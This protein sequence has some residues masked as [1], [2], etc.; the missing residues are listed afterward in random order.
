M[1]LNYRD[2]LAEV[3]RAATTPSLAALVGTVCI[4]SSVL[5]LITVFSLFYLSPNFMAK[6]G[7]FF[8]ENSEDD[9]AYLTTK[10]LQIKSSAPDVLNVVLM[11]ASDFK[12]ALDKKY[13][14]QV[15]LEETGYPVVVHKLTVVGLNFWEEICILD[16]I[17]EKLR[18]V[19]VLPISASYLAL[20]REY[21]QDDI[22]KHLR[23]ALY[24]PTFTKEMVR[25]GKKSPQWKGNYF[26]DHKRFFVVRLPFFLLNMV[27]NSPKQWKE[28][29]TW[30]EGGRWRRPTPDQWKGFVKRRI[31]QLEHYNNRHEENFQLY[32]RLVNRFQRNNQAQIVFLE[33]VKNP[34]V[35][36]SILS[37]PEVKGA[38][39]QYLGDIK[40]F[41][42][43]ANIPYWD[44]EVGLEPDDFIDHVHIKEPIAR[45]RY[46]RALAVKL[47]D[48]LLK[49]NSGTHQ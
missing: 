47:I 38:H 2:F 10:V 39:E 9:Y 44:L 27:A 37:N 45:K 40:E 43:K 32:E 20:G 18:G 5:A 35:E 12:E 11:G 13:L 4:A 3:W 36:S 1:S 6:Y 29:G 48:I 46:T 8:M 26:L 15:L 34:T 24:C 7:Y 25:I 31:T 14:Q 16:N 28:Y 21:I 42:K 22:T 23:T 33:T 41:S 17:H 49:L 30:S 19:I